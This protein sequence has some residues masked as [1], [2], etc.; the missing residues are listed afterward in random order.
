MTAVL[1]RRRT[2]LDVVIGVLL[3][4]GG[5]FMLSNAVLATAVSV[6]MIG[7]L[8]LIGGIME[9]GTALASIR[10]NFSWSTLLGGA[11]LTVLG[12]FMLRS[13][14]AGALALTIMAGAMFFASGIMRVGLALRMPSHR[15][16]LIAS[17]VI[18]IALALWIMVNPAKA[19]LTLLGVL[20]GVQVLT[21]G[22][23]MLVAGRLRVVADAEEPVA[24]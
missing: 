13:P 14:L 22:I 19:T 21:E 23:T 7:W 16:L 17:G 2:G 9:L 15:W 12:L 1:E 6:L 11:M 10:S 20:L 4:L 24:A 8:A 18:S 5:L 3:I